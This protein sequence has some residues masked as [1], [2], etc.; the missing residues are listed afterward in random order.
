MFEIQMGKAAV[1]W[2]LDN[3]QTHTHTKKQYEIILILH[4]ETHH[5]CMFLLE[6]MILLLNIQLSLSF[7][8]S[9]FGL[10]T[11]GCFSLLLACACLGVCVCL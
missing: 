7:F 1:K 5:L 11:S 4:M 2:F 9:F 8:L 6:Q 3:N 10:C